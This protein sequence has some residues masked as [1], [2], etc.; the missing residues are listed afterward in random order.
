MYTCIEMVETQLC[1]CYKSLKEQTTPCP[2][3]ALKNL[4]YCGIHMNCKVIFKLPHQQEKQTI[5]KH[6]QK[7]EPESPQVSLEDLPDNEILMLCQNIIERK[8]YRTL[9]QLVM[10]NQRIY[11]LC[12][13]MLTRSKR[14]LRPCSMIWTSGNETEAWKVLRM[15]QYRHHQVLSVDKYEHLMKHYPSPQEFEQL[16]IKHPKY[17]I[18]DVDE[19]KNDIVEHV[20]GGGNFELLT[21]LIQK[22]GLSLLNSCGLGNNMTPLMFY[23]NLRDYE[24]VKKLLELGVDVN[25]TTIKPTWLGHNFPT[26]ITALN[27]ALVPEFGDEIDV[28]LVKLLLSY[29]AVLGLPVPLP[30]T[31]DRINRLPKIIKTALSIQ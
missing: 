10:T 21:Y 15:W 28:N 9:A 31:D 19:Y 12:Q 8:E 3:K 25:R 13:P 30:I 20:L 1:Q 5:Q 22:Y 17:R 4:K 11:Q 23:V 29:D 2:H 16:L 14:E 18:T 7:Q 6:Q 26:G 24:V 27:V